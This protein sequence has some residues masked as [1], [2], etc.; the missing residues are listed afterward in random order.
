MMD[1]LA[2]E[3]QRTITPLCF[4]YFIEGSSHQLS[5]QLA[6]LEACEKV[7][8]LKSLSL[9]QTHIVLG[10]L[11]T[12]ASRHFELCGSLQTSMKRDDQ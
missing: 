12:D 1:T 5:F 4:R 3:Q 6:G 9:R 7:V 11:K 2:E 8:C 10:C